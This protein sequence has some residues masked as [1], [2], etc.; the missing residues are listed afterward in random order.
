MTNDEIVS[1]MYDHLMSYTVMLNN[2][3]KSKFYDRALTDLGICKELTI[4]LKYVK[5]HEV[6][7]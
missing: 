2:H 6:N 5:E 1:L 7:K 3:S 4:I